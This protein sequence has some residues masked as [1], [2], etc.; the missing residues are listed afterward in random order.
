MSEGCLKSDR[1]LRICRH[2]FK[3]WCWSYK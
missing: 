2:L 1:L 3:Y